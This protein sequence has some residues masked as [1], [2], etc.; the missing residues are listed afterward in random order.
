[1]ANDEYPISTDQGISA[2]DSDPAAPAD[3]ESA[4]ETGD[5]SD[6][7]DITEDTATDDDYSLPLSHRRELENGHPYRPEQRRPT[8]PEKPSRQYRELP[9]DQGFT[10]RSLMEGAMMVAI[11]LLLAVIGIYVPLVSFIGLLLYPLPM[12]I[13]TLRRG[14]KTGVAGTAALLALSAMFFGIP[15]AVMML[16]QYGVL[17][18]FLG[19]CLRSRRKPLFTLG[20]STLIAALGTAAALGLSLLVSGLPLSSLQD[21]AREML[22]M[23]LSAYEQAGTLDLLLPEGWTVEQ[24]AAYMEESMLRMLPSVLIIT[25]SLMTLLCYLLTTAILRRLGY[26]VARLPKFREWRLDW[27]LCWGLILGMALHLYGN[28]AGVDW[29]VTAGV[30]IL[31]VFAPILLVGGIAFFFWYMHVMDTPL[32]MRGILVVFGVVMFSYLMWFFMA[33]A[34]LDDLLDLRGRLLKLR[35]RRRGAA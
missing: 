1:M 20:L 30:S 35:D 14:V 26:D 12:A 8:I 10:V 2:A 6:T 29:A 28:H 19:W 9:P 24:Y 18:V 15:Q 13:L 25:A 16:L 23:V 5:T 4:G 34:V 17:G 7:N 32:F 33:A 22:D 27:R 3:I 11:S 21:Q 31:Y